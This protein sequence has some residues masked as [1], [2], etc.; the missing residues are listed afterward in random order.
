MVVY[1]LGESLGN[2][3]TL[4]LPQYLCR[5]TLTDQVVVLVTKNVVV[6]IVL[7]GRL[8]CE[9]K[10]LDEGSHGPAPDRK[11]TGHLEGRG[12]GGGGEGRGGEGNNFIAVHIHV[13][14]LHIVCVIG[15]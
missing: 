2:G 4:C 15:D 3:G 6:H 11:L 5:L 10:R 13:H 14:A 12:G 7:F 8:R 1:L 9:D